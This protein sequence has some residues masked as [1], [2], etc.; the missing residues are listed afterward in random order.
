MGDWYKKADSW[1]LGKSHSE[2]TKKKMSDSA[3]IS[4]SGKRNSQFGTMWITNE[5]ESKK[6][7]KTDL[8]P[9]GWRKGRKIKK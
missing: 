9:E 8:I 1:I 3:K 4:S 6:I 7:L 5:I 2:E